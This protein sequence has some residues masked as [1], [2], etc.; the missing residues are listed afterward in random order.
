LNSRRKAMDRLWLGLCVVAVG[1]AVVPFL[2]ILYD[3]ILKGAAR[4][5]MNFLTQL[6]PLPNGTD[7]GGLGNAIQGSLIVVAAASAFGLPVGVISGIY[8][9]EYG[10]NWYGS[11]IRFLGDVLAGIS[12]VVTGVLIYTLIVIPSHEFSLYAGAITLG[13]IMIPIV[14]NTSTQALKAVPNSIREASVALGVGKWRTTLVV[15]A[16]AK[17]SVATASLL[18]IARITGETAPII[19]TIGTSVYWFSSVNQPVATLT[20][21]IFYYATSPFQNWQQLAWTAS[22]FL[23]LMVLGINVVVRLLTRESKAYA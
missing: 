16:N 6:P 23:L 3:V 15:L 19:M 5:D 7:P 17:R 20:Y 14:S 10:S 1:V 4:F 11:S 9:S 2:A 12:S 13:S 22:M 18:A 8:V 21:Y